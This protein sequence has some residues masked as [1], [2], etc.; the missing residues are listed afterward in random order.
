[1]D[2]IFSTKCNTCFHF[3]LLALQYIPM[4]WIE[5]RLRARKSVSEVIHCGCLASPRGAIDLIDQRED[6]EVED[7]DGIRVF[8]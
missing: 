1:M 4:L 7:G 8:S 6:Q 5:E 3:T 2:I